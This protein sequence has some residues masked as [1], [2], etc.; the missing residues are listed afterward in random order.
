MR[1]TLLAATVAMVGS[2]GCSSAKSGGHPAGTPFICGDASCVTGQ[3]YCRML[4]APGGQ[5]GNNGPN[6]MIYYDCLPLNGDC[7]LPDC[8]CVT[9]NQGFYSCPTCSQLDSGAIIASCTKI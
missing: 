3:T 9:V 2:F 7:A 6:Q 5:N 8:S 1:I 4:A